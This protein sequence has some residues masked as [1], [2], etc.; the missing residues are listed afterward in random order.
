MKKVLYEKALKARHDK[1][2][3]FEVLSLSQT[4]TNFPETLSGPSDNAPEGDKWFKMIVQVENENPIEVIVE[5]RTPKYGV[6]HYRDIGVWV[7]GKCLSLV[8]EKDK[9]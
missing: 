5:Y 9:K 7:G 1:S 4:E 2:V 3:K 8:N 6:A